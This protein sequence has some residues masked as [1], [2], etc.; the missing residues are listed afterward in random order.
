MLSKFLKPFTCILPL[1]LL[2]G[3]SEE[4]LSATT[5]AGIADAEPKPE[6]TLAAAD[7]ISG[8]VTSRNGSEAGVWVIAETGEF[9]TFFARIV[10]TNDDGQYLIPNLPDAE[11]QVWTRGY[12]LA[13]SPKLTT[14]PGQTENL[15]AIIAAS[16]AIAAKVYPAAYWY[17]M[18]GLP[19]ENELV[20]IE[21]GLNAYLTWMKNM[22]CSTNSAG[23]QG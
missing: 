16:D 8:A 5:T 1:L 4:N 11:Y 6:T 22:G 19:T 13:D 21:G 10:V 2:I 15:E 9:D 20:N 12:G 18:M 23:F 17:S 14:R 3:C 7:A